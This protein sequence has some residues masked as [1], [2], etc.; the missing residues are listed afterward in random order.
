MIRS[1]TGDNVYYSFPVRTA[2]LNPFFNGLRPLSE[3]IY[4]SER[5]RDR[6]L[7][8]TGWDLLFNQKDEKVNQDIDLASLKDIRLYLYYTDFTE[9]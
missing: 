7:V 5:L 1:V 3:E 9:L 8:N 4:R 2:V 6:P